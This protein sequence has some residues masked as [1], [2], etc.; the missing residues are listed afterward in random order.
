M[1]L[2]FSCMFLTK[3]Q[4][5]AHIVPMTNPMEKD[6]VPRGLTK[7]LM[8]K[9]G[10]YLDITIGPFPT[11]RQAKTFCFFWGTE[12]CITT[13][14]RRKYGILLAQKLGSVHVWI[15]DER[16]PSMEPPSSS[17]ETEEAAE[18]EMGEL[19]LDAEFSCIDIDDS[20]DEMR[21][22]AAENRLKTVNNSPHQQQQQQQQQYNR[23]KVG[24]MST[25]AY[26]L[27]K[28][29]ETGEVRIQ[30]RYKRPY[31]I[32]V[33]PPQP[34]VPQGFAFFSEVTD[35]QQS[36]QYYHHQLGGYSASPAAPGLFA[37]LCEL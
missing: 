27:E 19:D 18:E 26:P 35:A 15:N 13:V 9:Q 34:C 36:S 20:V 31:P 3:N 4:K 32:Q 12:Q 22:C 24:L 30:T 8:T 10:W 33:E 5:H 1:F 29:P 21:L 14:D 6:V 2:W 37:R 7:S 23:N 11:A 25:G 16:L 17:M 28:I